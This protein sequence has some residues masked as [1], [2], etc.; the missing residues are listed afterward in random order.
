MINQD[1]LDRFTL[2]HALSGVL[3]AKAGATLPQVVFLA[4]GWEL[5][6]RPL[7]I[8]YGRY[9]P[10]PSQDSLVN[11]TLDASA[12]VIAYLIAR[13]FLKTPLALSRSS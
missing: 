6:E 7:K 4:V 13:K 9:F 3:A 5:L 10:H 12:M 8:K 1:P 2:V 11:A